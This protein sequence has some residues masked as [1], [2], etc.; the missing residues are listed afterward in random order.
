[1]Q[2]LDVEYSTECVK[3]CPPLGFR[4][5]KLPG[6]YFRIE[7]IEFGLSELVGYDQY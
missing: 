5:M 4:G 1:M 7:F 6:Y 3:I 2:V